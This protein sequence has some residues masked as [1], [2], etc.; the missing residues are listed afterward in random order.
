MNGY[1]EAMTI[2]TL[3]MQ[4]LEQKQVGSSGLAIDAQLHILKVVKEKLEVLFDNELAAMMSEFEKQ[5]K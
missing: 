1:L 4:R 3:E 5:D 2:I